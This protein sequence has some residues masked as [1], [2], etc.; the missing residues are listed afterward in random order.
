[1][2]NIILI[3]FLFFIYSCGYTSVYKNPG[4]Q[5]FQIIITEMQGDKDMNN[6]IKKEIELYSNKKSINRF[7]IVIKTDFV[8]EVLVKDGSGIITDYELY[9]NSTFIINFNDRTKELTFKETINIKNQTDNFDQNVYERSIKR[10]F[11]SSIREK[12]ISE[13]T[14][15][16]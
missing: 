12:L 10:N 5:N 6:L 4:N 13:I 1:M 15:I 16:K 3:I 2:K 14:N 8:K 11:A 7:D 9:T